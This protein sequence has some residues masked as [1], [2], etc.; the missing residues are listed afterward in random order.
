MKP[1]KDGQLKIDHS[2]RISVTSTPI[3]LFVD[4]ENEPPIMFSTVRTLHL[5]WL[6]SLR[7]S[8]PFKY[9]VGFSE[10]ASR[11]FKTIKVHPHEVTE[12]L[13]TYGPYLFMPTVTIFRS[14]ISPPKLLAHTGIQNG[15]YNIPGIRPTVQR[16][17]ITIG[18]MPHLLGATVCGN[19]I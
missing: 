2:N 5:I 1:W 16:G 13:Y 18:F 8:Y 4:I 11:A 17:G 14:N 6:Y 15:A 9:I 12:L 3:N 19:T 7:I 10:Y